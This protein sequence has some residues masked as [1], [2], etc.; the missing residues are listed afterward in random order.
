YYDNDDYY[1]RSYGPRCYGYRDGYYYDRD[2]RP[3]S[4]DGRPY[5]RRW[6]DCDYYYRRYGSWYGPGYCD[7]WDYDH[8]YCY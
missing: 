8:G 3:Y 6:D 7:R 5:Y 4:Y 2:G 1:Y